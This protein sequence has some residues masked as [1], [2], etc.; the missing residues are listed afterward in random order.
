MA[1]DKLDWSTTSIYTYISQDKINEIVEVINSSVGAGWYFKQVAEFDSDNP[2]T[3]SNGQRVKLT[4]PENDA[5]F[6]RVQ[7]LDLSYDYENQL[8][9]PTTE[10]DI[11]L[12][13]LRFKAIPSGSFGGVGSLKITVESPNTAFS[14]ISGDQPSF[15]R[16][17]G[18]EHFFSS[19]HHIFI[20]QELIDN[21]LEVYVEANDANVDLYDY[22]FT[23]T[24]L[25]RP[26]Q[27]LV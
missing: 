17:N 21:G 8:F 1:I 11:Y 7:N 10:D 2:V 15:V 24:R 12:T 16:G 5:G 19:H 26:V 22:S 4:I 27:E 6:E 14:P 3:I 23:L 20:G 25:F 9:K 18:D 13:T